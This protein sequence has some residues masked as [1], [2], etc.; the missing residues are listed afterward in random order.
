MA[1]SRTDLD[2][3]WFQA[4]AAALGVDLQLI[5]GGHFCLLEDTARAEQL[6]GTALA[7]MG[8]GRPLVA[9]REHEE[10]K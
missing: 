10:M 9:G 3:A 5:D 2:P 7:G 1:G 6:V 4:Q 8:H